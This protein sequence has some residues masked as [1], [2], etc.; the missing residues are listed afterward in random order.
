MTIATWPAGPMPIL[1]DEKSVSY[2][3]KAVQFGDGYK[4]LSKSTFNNKIKSG[5]LTFRA[6]TTEVKDTYADFLDDRAGVEPFNMVLPGEEDPTTMLVTKYTATTIGG[7][8]WDFV[9]SYE[10]Y[11]PTSL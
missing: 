11:Y 4:E 7:Y 2:R 3:T 1:G 9:F 5:T 8:L 10:Q 6:V